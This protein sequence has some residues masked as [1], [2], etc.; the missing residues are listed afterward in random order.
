[1]KSKCCNKEVEIVYPFCG[2]EQYICSECKHFCYAISSG[3]PSTPVQKD[4]TITDVLEREL[5]LQ[6]PQT[7]NGEVVKYCPECG[8]EN[9]RGNTPCTTS[10]SSESWV[11]TFE[12]ELCKKIRKSV[13][14]YAHFVYGG[15]QRAVKMDAHY[16]LT[17]G[18]SLVI[19][20]K[21]YELEQFIK[22]FIKN[23]ITAEVERGRREVVEKVVGYPVINRVEGELCQ[24]AVSKVLDDL[25]KELKSLTH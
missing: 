18:S 21:T 15:D 1:M 3:V 17:E 7:S 12:K 8:Y 6:S 16:L 13:F 11:E 14:E 2:G 9:C 23:T 4:K 5:E 25:I 19:K 10:P 22:S 24:R 20:N